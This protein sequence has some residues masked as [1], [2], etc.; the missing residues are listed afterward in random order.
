MKKNVRG[1]YRIVNYSITDGIA[2]ISNEYRVKKV[3]TSICF[4][5]VCY[6]NCITDLHNGFILQEVNFTDYPEALKK[7]DVLKIAQYKLFT[8]E[9]LDNLYYIIATKY[10]IKRTKLT[11]KSPEPHQ[12]IT[13]I[14]YKTIKYET[15]NG[16]INEDISI[17]EP[18]KALELIKVFGDFDKFRIFGNFDDFIAW[19]S[20]LMQNN[21]PDY[22]EL[23]EICIQK[24]LWGSKKSKIVD[25][26]I[27]NQLIK[28]IP[29]SIRHIPKITLKN[30]SHR[31]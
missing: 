14:K 19:L 31:G 17:N 18:L 26:D 16:R 10:S 29:F 2:E 20:N 28:E 12:N 27:N 22:S 7:I 6:I 11:E 23:N 15:S 9:N 8:I 25:Y 4:E 13:N 21:I 30:T 3:F 24:I 5:N 1:C